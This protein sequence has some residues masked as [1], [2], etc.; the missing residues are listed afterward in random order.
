MLIWLLELY[1]GRATA[2]ARE[3]ITHLFTHYNFIMN[4]LKFILQSTAMSIEENSDM[5]L[6]EMFSSLHEIHIAQQCSLS[7]LNTTKE[8][9]KT[10]MTLAD[11]EMKSAL[12]ENALLSKELIYLSHEVKRLKTSVINDQNKKINGL[13]TQKYKKLQKIEILKNKQEKLDQIKKAKTVSTKDYKM[14]VNKVNSIF[15]DDSDFE[16]VEKQIMESMSHINDFQ[17]KNEAKDASIRVLSDKLTEIEV[18][19]KV[20]ENAGTEIRKK[21]DAS[22]VA[23]CQA[24]D[25]EVRM[26]NN[27]IDLLKQSQAAY[28]SQLRDLNKMIASQNHS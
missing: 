2:L 9:M 5:S 12:Q 28:K 14:K 13:T 11:N 19:E 1:H 16:K 15:V 7:D 6:E 23:C 4:K 22:K 10:Q 21:L 27:K 17:E 24:Y 26:L 3:E 18:E 8:A 25:D 20:L